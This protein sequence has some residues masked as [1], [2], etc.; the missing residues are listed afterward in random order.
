MTQDPTGR[1]T[2]KNPEIPRYSYEHGARRDRWASDVAESSSVVYNGR[3]E[4]FIDFV[5]FLL[6]LVSQPV[7]R[8][9]PGVFFALLCF[10]FPA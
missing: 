10:A 5:H 9:G 4:R 8:P 3:Y 1:R 2:T 7:H 6:V